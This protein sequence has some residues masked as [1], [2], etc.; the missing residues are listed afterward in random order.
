[1]GE[2]LESTLVTHQTG[3]K[4]KTVLK[5]YIEEAVEINEELYLGIVLDRTK[6]M[7]VIM[8]SNE[9][10]MDI[11]AVAEATPEKIAKVPIDPIIGFMGF[12][13]RDL[14]FQL[15]IK[16]KE[17][18]KKLIKFVSNL[19][20]LYIEKDAELIEI[21]PLI[22][23]KSGE[24]LAL[25]AK[26]GFDDSALQRQQQIEDM[27]DVT[28]EDP[29]EREASNY[30][31]SYISLDGEI[32]CVVNGAGLDMSTMDI[33]NYEGGTVANFLDVGGKANAET[34]AKGFEI[35]LR[36]PKVKAIFVN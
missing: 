12:H 30:G 4:G 33:I 23:T 2:M 1:M 13:G 25:D 10:G 8:A 26:M 7:P 15:H 16:D 32:G 6:E 11:E 21:N 35:I 24:F 31:L 28:E 36:N 18:Q 9:G 34:V 19:Y 17:E 5:V 27:R 22:K 14:V 3:P 20:D 29:N